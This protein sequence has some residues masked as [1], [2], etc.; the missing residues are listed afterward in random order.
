MI[1]KAKTKHWKTQTK[2]IDL[3]ESYKMFKRINKGRNSPIGI[4]GDKEDIIT[5]ENKISNVIANHFSKISSEKDIDKVIE[6]K[7]REKE[8]IYKCRKTWNLKMK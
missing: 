2:D 6:D 5:D 1:R 8:H 3:N 4:N 7:Q